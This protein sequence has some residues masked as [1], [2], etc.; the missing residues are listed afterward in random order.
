MGVV[1]LARRED[2]LG[3]TEDA[4]EDAGGGDSDDG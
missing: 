2:D 3:D 4:D 1:G